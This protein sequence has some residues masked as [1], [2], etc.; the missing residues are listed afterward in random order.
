[1]KNVRSATLAAALVPIALVAAQPTDAYAQTCG[2][3][4]EPPCPIPEPETL[5]LLG[6]AA[7]ALLVRNRRNAKARPVADQTEA[8]HTD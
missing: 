5:L 8:N 2:I 1:L 3:C 7:A 4:G 6:P